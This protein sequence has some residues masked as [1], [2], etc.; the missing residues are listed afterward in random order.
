M[1]KSVQLVVAI[2]A[3]YFFVFPSTGM[4]SPEVT[5]EISDYGVAE[6]TKEE[7]SSAKAVNFGIVYGISDFGL[8]GQLRN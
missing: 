3:N 8:A 5:S 7:R 6:V 2:I 1:K 4:E